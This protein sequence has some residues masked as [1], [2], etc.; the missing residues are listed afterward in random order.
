MLRPAVPDQPTPEPLSPQARAVLE[1]ADAAVLRYEAEFPCGSR[2]P[3]WA[4]LCEAV[5][6]YRVRDL[7]PEGVRPQTLLSGT[8][9]YF[10]GEPQTGPTG[11]IVQMDVYGGRRAYLAAGH[12]VCQFAD[13]DLVCPLHE[14]Q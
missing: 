12:V 4:R 6:A 5:H 10:V 14:E 9:F 11:E 1:A 13:G 3:D 8:R 2:K 7:Q